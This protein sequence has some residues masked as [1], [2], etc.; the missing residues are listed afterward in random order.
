MTETDVS[1]LARVETKIDAL[2]DKMDARDERMDERCSIR[3]ERLDGMDKRLSAV[4]H[5][6]WW[7]SG[8]AAAVGYIA[9]KLP[10]LGA[11]K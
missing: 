11:G 5:R 4:E 6:I 3:S 2:I 10:F 9:S 1:R 8:A 7:F